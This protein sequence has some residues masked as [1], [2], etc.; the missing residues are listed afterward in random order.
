MALIYVNLQ[1][2]LCTL[3][4]GIMGARIMLR[5]RLLCRAPPCS[6][7]HSQQLFALVLLRFREQK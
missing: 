1:K 4:F 5:R 3:R 6:I 7:F 2:L